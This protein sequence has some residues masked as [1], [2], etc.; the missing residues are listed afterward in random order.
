MGLLVQLPNLAGVRR[1]AAAVPQSCRGGRLMVSAAA[2]GGRV[3]EEEEEAKGAGKKER[4]V[5]RVSDPV[6]ERRLPPPLFSAPDE[7]SERPPDPD[8]GTRRGDEDG[9]EAKKQYYVNMGDAIRTLREE[10]PVVFY[11]E[12]SFDIYRFIAGEMSSGGSRP[13]PSYFSTSTVLTS[14]VSIRTFSSLV[15]AASSPSGFARR[16]G[17]DGGRARGRAGETQWRGCELCPAASKGASTPGNRRNRSHRTREARL[18]WSCSKGSAETG[19][20]A[21]RLRTVAARTLMGALVRYYVQ[22]RT[23]L[24]QDRITKSGGTRYGRKRQS[25][26]PCA[27]ALQILRSGL[28]LSN[29]LSPRKASATPAQSLPLWRTTQSPPDTSTWPQEPTQGGHVVPSKHLC[30]C[31]ACEPWTDAFPRGPVPL[32]RRRRRALS[33]RN[34]ILHHHMAARSRQAAKLRFRRSQ[35]RP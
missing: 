10:L 8:V 16:R 6:R 22:L 17:H 21:S 24:K 14:P 34:P 27:A 2:P 11:R 4:I 20:T 29:R 33:A 1:P 28:A 15:G 32:P 7:T 18:R 26:T 30:L 5:I 3:K 25:W 12:P 23:G 13:V 31:M 19:S 35:S 9:E